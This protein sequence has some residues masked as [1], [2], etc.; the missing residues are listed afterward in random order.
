[1]KR[2]ALTFL[3]VVALCG[4]AFALSSCAG[5]YVGVGAGPV[6]Y[7]EGPYWYG[8]GWWHGGGW[9]HGGWAHPGFHHY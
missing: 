2:L 1:M 5:G 8:G 4:G 7:D 6:Y 9:H 3:G